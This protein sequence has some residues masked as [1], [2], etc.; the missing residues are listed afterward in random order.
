LNWNDLSVTVTGGASFIGSHL[1]EKLLELGARVTVA[2]DFS[3]GRLDNLRAC[4]GRI[5][6]HR[7]N[8]REYSEARAAIPERAYVFHLAAEHGGRAFID[9]HPFECW[10]NITLDQIVFRASI[11]RNCRKIIYAG[12]ACV[13]PV[14][15]QTKGQ[16]VWLKE[17]DAGYYGNR[18]EAD[19][20]YG[21]AKLIGEATLQ[22]LVKQRGTKAAPARIFSAYGPRENETHAVLA[23]I[24]RA[25]IHQDPFVIWGDGQQERNFTYVDD[26]VDGLIRM[27]ERVDDGRPVNLGQDKAVV[28]DEGVRLVCKMMRH[29]PKF[30]YDASKP[31]GVYARMADLTTAM[32]ILNWRPTT[33]FEDGLNPTIDWYIANRDMVIVRENLEKVLFERDIIPDRGLD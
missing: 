4:K 23:W 7:A 12:S 20:E 32:S 21:W 18:R 14:G 27:A 15:L 26:I 9:T 11:D 17:E 13:Y 3:S 30:E 10:S 22:S 29:D 1:V 31:V 33:S 25:F 6:I 19:G 24:A 5:D 28:M 16:R 8:L 2:D